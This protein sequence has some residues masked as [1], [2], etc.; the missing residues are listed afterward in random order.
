[1]TRRSRKRE[2]EQAVLQTSV[3][4]RCRL[5]A[6]RNTSCVCSP[7]NMGPAREGQ[8]KGLPAHGA[9]AIDHKPCRRQGSCLT[10]ACEAEQHAAKN[11]KRSAARCLPVLS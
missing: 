6:H 10:R 11:E 9:A 8:L 5:I 2:I 1:M 7:A 3:T 4:E